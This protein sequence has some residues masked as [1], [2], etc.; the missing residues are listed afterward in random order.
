VVTGGNAS[1]STSALQ[2]LGRVT[3]GGTLALP[4]GLPNLRQCSDVTAGALATSAGNVQIGSGMVR[5]SMGRLRVTAANLGKGIYNFAFANWPANATNQLPV[6][7][8]SGR[9]IVT[10]TATPQVANGVS[11]VR[12]AKR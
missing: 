3:V 1:L 2:T 12:M 4:Q 5:S 9:S 6:A 7:I 10:A 11:I 8:V